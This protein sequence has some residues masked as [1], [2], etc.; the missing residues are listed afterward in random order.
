MAGAAAVLGVICLIASAGVIQLGWNRTKIARQIVRTPVSNVGSLSGQ[1]DV[2]EIRGQIEAHPDYDLLDRPFSDGGCVYRDWTVEKRTT[3]ARGRWVWHTIDED[4]GMIPFR[5]TDGTGTV[6]I[7]PRTFDSILID[8]TKEPGVT[9][10]RGTP[11]EFQD[12]VD[13]HVTTED[14]SEEELLKE[15]FR[16][17]DEAV[18]QR[19]KRTPLIPGLQKIINP[20]LPQKRDYLPEEGENL[21]TAPQ[22]FSESVLTVGD[23]VTVYGTPVR[24]AQ[25]N[26]DQLLLTGNQTPARTLISD[27]SRRRLR[28]Q[29]LTGGARILYGGVLAVASVATIL[30]L[31]L[32]N[33][34]LSLSLLLLLVWSGLGVVYVTVTAV[35]QGAKKLYHRYVSA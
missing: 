2:V 3:D 21:L 25:R 31:F 12:F 5:V 4:E 6:T 22:R 19:D 16:L 17:P 13:E 18:P 34:V 30:S 32:S 10:W 9:T 1:D 20:P 7:S 29:L 33:L 26:A 24:A 27:Y 23:E 35:W 15:T 14:R 8:T 28:L 11:E